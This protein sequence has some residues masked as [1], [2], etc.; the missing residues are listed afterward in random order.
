MFGGEADDLA[1]S[2]VGAAERGE[3]VLEDDDLVVGRRDLGEPV[4]VGGAERAL[5]GRRAVG[6]VLPVRGDGHPFALGLVEAGLGGAVHRFEGAAVGVSG[7]RFAGSVPGVVVDELAAVRQGHHG[8]L[9]CR[10]LHASYLNV[11]KRKRTRGSIDG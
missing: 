1:A 3:A 7:A 10:S 9:H 2:A 8:L 6:A 5:V 4:S 11:V